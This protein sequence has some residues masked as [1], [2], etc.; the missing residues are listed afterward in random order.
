MSDRPGQDGP[1]VSV[2]M[3]F[4]DAAP[5]IRQATGSVL[6]QSWTNLELLLVDDGGTDGSD[7]IARRL[8]EADPRV[9]VLSHE[10]RRNRGT[11]PSRALAIGHARG[12]LVAFLDADDAWEPHHVADQIALLEAHPEADIV[13]GRAWVWRSWRHPAATDVLSDLAFVPGAVVSGRQLLAAVLRNGAVATS[14][15]SL[16]ARRETLLGVV[17]HVEAFT[18]LFEDQVVNAWLQLRGTAVMS[19]ATSA[20]YRMHDRSISARLGSQEE[21]RVYL[22]FLAWVRDQLGE[23]EGEGDAELVELID[24]ASRRTTESLPPPQQPRPG[25]LLRAVVPT[26]VRRQIG[27]V[28]RALHRP[29]TPEPEVGPQEVAEALHRHGADLRGDVLV[30]G[31]G[32]AVVG[33]TATTSVRALPLPGPQAAAGPAHVL[34]DLASDAYDCV[35]LVEDAGSVE[36]GDRGLRHLRRALRPGGVL[37]VVPRRDDPSLAE[38]LQAVFEWDAVSRDAPG[39]PY[40]TVLRAFVPAP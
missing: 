11:G 2:V 24:R 32:T 40:A 1:V 19:G 27:R 23:G 36:A 34:A 12:D 5:H 18:G 33:S 38:D 25:H 28:R 14:T 9:R 29:R 15:C 30:L 6:R 21:A 3:P 13:C 26:A 20:W 37:L 4:L 39:G 7:R 35:L 10:G 16:L 8:A 31:D 17:P 22:R